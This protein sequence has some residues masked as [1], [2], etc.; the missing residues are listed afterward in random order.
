MT[1]YVL[2]P[3]G[4]IVFRPEGGAV[5]RPECVPVWRKTGILTSSRLGCPGEYAVILTARDSRT[6]A[7]EFKFSKLT[8][9]REL[10]GISTATINV[11]DVF[12]GLRCNVEFGGV[13]KPWKFGIR[14]EADGTEMFSG[15]IVSIE[16]PV[17]GQSG[18]DYLTI[19]ANDLMAWTRKRVTPDTL[20]FTD[21]DAGVVFKTV[22]DAGMAADNLPGLYCPEFSTGLTM[23]REVVARDFEITGDILQEVA[24]SAVDYFMYGTSLVVYDAGKSVRP[25]GWYM[26]DGIEDRRFL[27]SPDPYGRFIFG[28]FTSEAWAERPGYVLDGFAQSNDVI[29]AGADSGEA[30]FRRFWRSNGGINPEIGQLTSVEVSPLYR[31]REGEPIVDDAVFQERADSMW[32]LR[33]NAVAVISGGSLSED[34]PVSLDGLIPGSLWAVDLAEHGL[35]D[36]L[37]VQRLKRVDVEVTFD[38]AGM[39]QRVTPTLIPLGTD[40]GTVRDEP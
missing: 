6:F 17:Q 25:A 29:V 34:A 23:T 26:N 8:W 37:T 2:K 9:S 33:H 12:G 38:Q 36:L 20:M 40:E 1:C 24:D 35:S 22:L 18:A 4:G 3:D 30:G 11:P 15:P 16:R 21:E 19:T 14:I 5:L 27:E 32:D 13:V 31:S 10:D 28:L 39:R 7:G